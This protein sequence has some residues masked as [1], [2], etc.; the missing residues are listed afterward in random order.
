MH[1]L[2]H[3]AQSVACAH[4]TACS[5]HTMA[6]GAC[7]VTGAPT[8][9]MRSQPWMANATQG[10]DRS[11]ISLSCRAHAAAQ[12]CTVFH[13]GSDSVVAARCW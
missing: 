9:T 13:Q 12:R 7:S 6:G 2:L 5:F 11:A 1:C 4:P 10:T 3:D 8:C